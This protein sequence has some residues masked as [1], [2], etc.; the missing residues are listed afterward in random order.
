MNWVG[1]N[2]T[3]SN[4]VKSLHAYT[5]ETLLRPLGGPK[6]A[7]PLTCLSWECNLTID[8][9]PPT[10]QTGS[11]AATYGSTANP[12]VLPGQTPA[13]LVNPLGFIQSS[14][15]GVTVD[16]LLKNKPALTMLLHDHN[17]LTNENVS[18]N[19]S[20]NTANTYV[21]G[22]E[23]TKTR[24]KTGAIFQAAAAIPIAFSIN[25]LTGGNSDLTTTGWAVL[26]IGLAF[27]A[28]GLYYAFW[29]GN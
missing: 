18:L 7:S 12:N 6:H 8:S 9:I 29:E 25:I 15:A 19:N 5:R 27:Q 24:A 1:V 20:L 21:R 28:I 17:R 16:D 4:P 11:A 3:G 26:A 13:P 2:E 23:E 10:G 22:Y 14:L